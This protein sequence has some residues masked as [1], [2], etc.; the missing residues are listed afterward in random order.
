MLISNRSGCS[1]FP[2]SIASRISNQQLLKTEL[3][4]SLPG[5]CKEV[6]DIIY[7]FY[8]VE[9]SRVPG[10]RRKQEGNLIELLGE[11][12]EGREAKLC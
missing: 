7:V 11:K 12:G 8:R 10:W 4:F 3:G 2:C 6:Q 9:G 1:L 5:S